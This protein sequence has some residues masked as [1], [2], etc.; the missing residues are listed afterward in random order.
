MGRGSSTPQRSR[1]WSEDP[2]IPLP[3]VVK[4]LRPGPPGS[5]RADPGLR[6][7]DKS[8]GGGDGFCFK[9]TR[10]RAGGEDFISWDSETGNCF[11]VLFLWF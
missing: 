5:L 4:D 6:C 1:R 10:V 11:G 2:G 8:C 9:A 3:A 7:K